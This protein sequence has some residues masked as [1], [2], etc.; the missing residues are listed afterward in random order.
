M[1]QI[2]PTT[3]RAGLDAEMANLRTLVTRNL[4]RNAVGRAQMRARGIKIVQN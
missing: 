4:P 3:V 1:A 2:L